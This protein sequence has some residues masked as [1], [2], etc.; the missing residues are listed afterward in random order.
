[1]FVEVAGQT[2]TGRRKFR[3][4]SPR[5]PLAAISRNPGCFLVWVD[6]QTADVAELVVVLINHFTVAN[7]LVRIGDRELGVAQFYKDIILR[8]LRLGSLL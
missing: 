6:G 1:M 5:N 2:S 8:M 3:S 4:S 7:L